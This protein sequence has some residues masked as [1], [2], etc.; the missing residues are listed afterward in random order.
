[1]EGADPHVAA[2]F[3]CAVVRVMSYRSANTLKESVEALISAR[4]R[5]VVRACECTLLMASPPG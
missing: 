2:E 3:L 1:M 4:M 5:G